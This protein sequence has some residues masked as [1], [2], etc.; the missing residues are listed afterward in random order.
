MEGDYY[1][2]GKCEGGF[3][4]EYWYDGRNFIQ[5]VGAEGFRRWN[6]GQGL[7]DADC[8][9]TRVADRAIRF[10][11]KHRSRSF[12]FCASFDEPHSPMSAPER[13][14]RLYEGSTRP[15]QEN[16]SD[17]LAGKPAVHRAYRDAHPGGH[18]PRGTRPN[19]NPRYYG[20]TSF[21][22]EQ[23]GRI[24]EAVDRLCADDTAILFTSDHGDH[25]GAHGMLGKG[26]T[27]Y[28]ET[29]RVPMLARVP[30]VTRPGSVCDALVSH[31]H[32]VPMIL[33]LLGLPAHPQFQ[34]GDFLP[35]LQDPA[36]RLTDAVFLEYG[37]FGVPH[38]HW[39]GFM[40][41][42]CIRAERWKLVLNLVDR[43]EL[44]DLAAD[45]G[46]LVNRIDDPALAEVRNGLH[47]RLLAWM[48]ERLDPLRGRGWH[49][50]P[51]RPGFDLDPRQR[52][53]H[54]K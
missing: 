42:R 45:P 32:H 52:P 13:F 3:L 19:N 10:I 30:G 5:E 33:R 18:V 48:E 12:F 9:G 34:A 23:I 51:W 14:Y 41:S 54:R 31:I 21:A 27:M 8:W 1:G 53:R 22:D 4:P 24:V 43:D 36:A 28:E 15:W 49:F 44:Y 7:S 6:A 40:P 20:C 26:P 25:H 29:I 16:M 35:L 37:R 17:D 11:E 39:W 50:R 38:S 47:D 2:Q 46:E